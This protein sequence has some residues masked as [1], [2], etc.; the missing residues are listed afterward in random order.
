MIADRAN[1]VLRRAHVGEGP[2][3]Q[4]SEHW[5]CRLLDRHTEYH[6]SKQPVQGIDRKQE[7]GPDAILWWLHELK[8]IRD[9]CGIQCHL[10]QT[11]P[12]SSQLFPSPF[13]HLSD[14]QMSCGIIATLPALPIGKG[15][16]HTLRV[17]LHEYKLRQ[18]Q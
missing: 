17:A 18:G 4:V 8:S 13:A 3:P 15:F 1:G 16:T 2:P 12:P 7:Q 9:E 11:A 6:V 5:A 10:Q 14:K